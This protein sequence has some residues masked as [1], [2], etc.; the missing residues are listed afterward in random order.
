MGFQEPGPLPG[1]SLQR[2][3]WVSLTPGPWRGRRRGVCTLR[4]CSL[5]WEPLRPHLAPGTELLS[6]CPSWASLFPHDSSPA[7]LP[8]PAQGGAQVG[9]GAGRGPGTFCS[10]LHHWL[11]GQECVMS[12][13]VVT[14][15]QECVLGEGARQRTWAE[16][17]SPGSSGTGGTEQTGRDVGRA[18]RCG[19][20]GWAW[21]KAAP[22]LEGRKSSMWGCVFPP[23]SLPQ[24][25]EQENSEAP[26]EEGRHQRMRPKKEGPGGTETKPHSQVRGLPL[27]PCR[28]R[29][30]PSPACPGTQ[31]EH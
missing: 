25:T 11:P 26:S 2:H 19:G 8:C 23:K 9:L 5:R 14:G 13:V 16:P 22:A 17:Q 3:P 4:P 28:R 10:F 18:G 31:P 12:P 7:P 21:P 20:R 15:L 24:A 27:C 6:P 29:P 1:E 30:L